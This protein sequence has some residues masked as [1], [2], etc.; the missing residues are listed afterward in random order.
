[1]IKLM[2]GSEQKTRLKLSIVEFHILTA[3]LIFY[4]SAVHLINQVTFQ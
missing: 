4:I 2:K 3:K 1:M